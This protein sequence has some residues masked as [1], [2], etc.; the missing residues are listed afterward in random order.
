MNGRF[1]K[2]ALAGCIVMGGLALAA[3]VL[4]IE[5][6]ALSDLWPF[7]HDDVSITDDPQNAPS[8]INDVPSVAVHDDTSDA[9]IAFVLQAVSDNLQRNDLTAAKVLLDEVLAVHSDL[10]QA[11]ALQQEL[12]VREARAAHAAPP[13]AVAANDNTRPPAAME[14]RETEARAAAGKQERTVRSR[15][16][17]SHGTNHVKSRGASSVA[18]RKHMAVVSNGRP[19]TRAEVVAELKRARANGTVPNFGGRHR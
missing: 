4:H 6:N 19:K 16:V 5:S 14:T 12:R 15:Q 1:D 9:D 18:Q 17:A 10:P 11:L 3:V 13:L 2:R 8:P 7:H